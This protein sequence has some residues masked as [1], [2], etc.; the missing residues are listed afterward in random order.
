MAFEAIIII[1]SYYAHFQF[2]TLELYS[3]MFTC[4]NVT[5]SIAA[6]PL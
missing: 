3:K 2:H 5:L 1:I 4:F 6:A